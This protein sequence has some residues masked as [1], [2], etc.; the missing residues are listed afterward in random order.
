M[1][2]DIHHLL[3][4]ILIKKQFNE[5]M[6]SI[7]SIVLPTNE[8]F[9]LSKN[10]CKVVDDIGGLIRMEIENLRNFTNVPNDLLVLIEE[11]LKNKYQ[12]GC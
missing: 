12:Y 7:T 10:K 3:N 6:K 8:H 2:M 9:N 5:D 1:S 4:K 11:K